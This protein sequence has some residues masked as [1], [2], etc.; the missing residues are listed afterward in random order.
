M[1]T[2]LRQLIKTPGFTVIC[3]VTLA[4]GIGLNTSMFSLMNLLI[5]KPLPYPQSDQ[6]VR[7]YRVNAQNPTAGHSASDYLALTR[8]LE[9]VAQIAA[10][11]QW[12]YTLVAEGRSPTN[13]S[14]QRVS[15]SFLPTLAL[16]PELGRWFTPEEDRPGSHVAILGYETW[17]AQ[18]GGDPTIVGKSVRIDGYPTVIVGVMPRDFSSAFL[19]GPTDVLTPLGLTNEE[20]ARTA[21]AE[22]ALVARRS[23]A[24]SLAEFN[25]RLGIIARNLAEVRS[26][27][28]SEDGLRAVTLESVARN[29][30]S[31]IIS[32]MMVAV[33]AFVLLIACANLA[34]LQLA[35]A[36]ARA[37]EYAVRMALGA[38]QLKL[39]RPVM[40]ESLLLSLGGGALGVLVA[41][42]ANDWIS[43][44]VS[45]QGLIHLTLEID[46]RVLL[47]ALGVSVLTGLIFGLVPAWR[48]TRVRVNEALKGSG[49][50]QTSDRA[51]SRLQRHLIASQFANALILLSGA[52]GFIHGVD[53]LTTADPGWDQPYITQT[54]LNLP[55]ARYATP[56]QSYAFYTQLDER[57]RTLPGVQDV[58][59]AWTLPVFQYLT[60]RSMVVEG[61]EPPPPGREPIVYINGVMPSYLPTLGLKV[62][63]GRN[64]TAADDAKAVRVAII[65]ASLAQA[66]FPNEDPIGRRIGHPDP[67]NPNWLEI[68]GV[69]SDHKYAIGAVPARTSHLLL[70]PL[71]QETWNYVT[72]ALRSQH[73]ALLVEPLRQTIATLDS[74]LAPQ[75]LGTIKDATRLITGSVTM[76]TTVLTGF[77]LLGLFLAAIGIYGVVARTV[78]RRTPEIGLRMAL[79][80]QTGDVVRMV[81]FS[82]LKMALI[83]TGFGLIG[84]LALGFTL[85]ALVSDTSGPNWLVTALVVAT[86]TAVALVACWL[87]ARRAAKV[88]PMVPLRAE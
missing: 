87:P 62:Q 1:K 64:F 77:A 52:A 55:T 9:G 60:T 51:Q 14:A 46:W 81:L 10:M 4:L 45:A 49:R 2:A 79:G 78:V 11:R 38:S 34:N 19:W 23:A 72:V 24:L 5:L 12:G 69:V 57:L 15:S 73:P 20:M 58:T 7:I 39:L 44:R 29:P 50:G 36:S 83:G 59:V 22:I 71:A 37:H 85:Q 67:R 16:K 26:K 56:E 54:V 25:T 61:R 21:E 86:L 75:Q 43:S 6:L 47:F 76:M 32:W 66:L 28:F 35:R 48:V 33:A 84:S 17:Q 40:I 3:L 13:L 74:E 42:W 31:K 41:A 27:E 18:F 8:E 65:N 82:G 63:S 70:V 80:A 53:N 88:D 68:V 30:G